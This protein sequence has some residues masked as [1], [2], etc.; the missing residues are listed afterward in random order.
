MVPQ[1]LKAGDEVR[2]VAPA[3][4]LRLIGRDSREIAKARFEEMGLKVTFGRNTTDENWDMFGS[5]DVEKRAEDLNEAF[6]DKNVKA[7]FTV[8]GGSNSNQLLPYLD[9]ELIR[10]NPK[11]FCGFSD[12]TAL[13]NGIYA[14]TGLVTFSGPHFSSLGMKKGAEY[15]LENLKKMILGDQKNEIKPSDAWSDD[16]WFINQEDRTFIKNEGWQ[17]INAGKAEGTIVGG[18]LGTF[19][20][21]LGSSYRP[22][23]EKNTVLFVEECFT[24]EA[25]D[26]GSFERNLQALI[27][28]PD[29]ENVSGIVIGRFQ[30]A[31]NVTKE[32]LEYIIKSKKALDRMPVIANVDFGHTTPLLTLPIGGECSLDAESGLL[33]VKA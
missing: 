4:G 5:T 2:I 25:T 12:I 6:G 19:D 1:V 15:T 31:S 22:A 16:L 30:K 26:A 7:I 17:V 3:R 20:L 32:K 28:Q 10:Q 8:I 13:L 18:N 9:Y 33:T 11:I 24:S 29:F 14:K 21:L 23:F 27:Y